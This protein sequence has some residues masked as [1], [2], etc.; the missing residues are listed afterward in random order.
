[1]SLSDEIFFNEN[2]VKINNL[3]SRILFITIIVPVSFIILTAL[4]IWR[5]PHLFSIGMIVYSAVSTFI[6]TTCN[7]YKKTQ[8]MAMYCG[9]MFSLLFIE[10]LSLEHIVTVRLSYCFICFLSC[11]YYN[12]KA[13]IVTSIISFL[14]MITS[15]WAESAQFRETLQWQLDNY[16]H[17]TYFISTVSG[18]VVEFIFV[19]IICLM[20]SQRTRTTLS[21]LVNSYEQR[22]EAYRELSENNE[23]LKDTQKKIIQFVAQCLGSHD[24]FTGRHVIHTQSYVQTIAQGLRDRGYYQDELDDKTIELFSTAAFL[25]D[26]GKI[27]IPEGVLNKIGK[28]TRE[29]FEL[30]QIHPEEGFKLLEYLPIIDDG[31]F[32][33]IAKNMALYHHE[34]WD[35]SGYPTK[36]MQTDIPL[37]ARIM[38]AADVLDALVCQRLY[39]EPMTIDEAMEIFKTSSGSHFEPCIAE[40]VIALKE[41]LSEINERYKTVESSSNAIELE[42]WQKYHNSFTV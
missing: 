3:V 13:T 38:A 24:L 36:K 7:K 31:K 25:H 41:E 2:V 20:F 34:K 12:R 23:K 4:H 28:F 39:K 26:I 42:W 19:I 1:M 8:Q 17:I 6:V 29:E 11:L 10:I 21:Q 33:E 35:G 15:I 5:V 22:N 18:L 14:L 16:N 37:C 40:T 30:M 32:N 27:H 9:L